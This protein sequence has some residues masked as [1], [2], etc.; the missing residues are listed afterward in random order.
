MTRNWQQRAFVLIATIAIGFALL[1]LLVPM[2]ALHGHSTNTADLVA[3][4]PLLLVGILSLP[5]LVGPPV[6]AYRGRV[7][8]APLLAAAFERPPPTLRG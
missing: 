2:F 6:F 3:I 4:L 5:S 7:P 1:F 8:Q